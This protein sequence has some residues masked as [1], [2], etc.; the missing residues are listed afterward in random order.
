MLS[1]I[2]ILS[3]RPSQGAGRIQDLRFGG[4]WEELSVLEIECPLRMLVAATRLSVV[5]S[6]LS[7]LVSELEIRYAVEI[8]YIED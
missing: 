5:R 7:Q 2:E 3:W 8:H 6:E 1:D 4:S